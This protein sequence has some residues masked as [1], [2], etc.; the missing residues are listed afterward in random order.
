[1]AAHV[2]KPRSSHLSLY[3]LALCKLNY[4]CF[5]LFVGYSTQSR[6]PSEVSKTRHHVS[7]VCIVS[8]AQG[9]S[10]LFVPRQVPNIVV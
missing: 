5:C 6:V 10:I 7:T 9:T 1:M 8:D 2:C 4:L 3:S